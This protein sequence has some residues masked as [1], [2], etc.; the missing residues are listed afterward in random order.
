MK[1]NKEEIQRFQF[2][3]EEDI[4]EQKKNNV[5]PD[6]TLEESKKN[7][8]AKKQN[9]HLNSFYISFQFRVILLLC[10]ILICFSCGCVCIVTAL[11]SVKKEK[12]E[13]MES[14]DVEYK[15]CVPT[16]DPYLTNCLDYSNQ[17]LSS[18]VKEIQIDFDYLARTKSAR[19]LS[20]TYHITAINRIFDKFDSSKKLYENSEIVV[21]ET[22]IEFENNQA[23]KK[24]VF[25]IDFEKYNN[26]IL[27]YQKNYSYSSEAS[28]ELVVWIN[29]G[30]EEYQAG[31]MNIPLGAEK[32]IM[33]KNFETNKRRVVSI[34]KE[35]NSNQNNYYIVVGAVLI[36]LAMFA[37][38]YLTK[39]A[40]KTIN[41]QS[42]Y[43]K[44]LNELL[45][46][47]D[48]IIVEARGGY[49]SNTVKKVIKVPNFEE[50]LDARDMLNKPIIFSKVNNIKSEF[51]VEDDDKLY[52][53][54]LKEVDIEKEMSKK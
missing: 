20:L 48:R 16:D 36:L 7:K 24:S 53:Y 21:P 30:E 23:A 51:I 38:T 54:V 14:A 28:L 39:L 2:V 13:Y 40:L 34:K 12:V 50:L 52:K 6:D 5:E 41:R 27:E 32:F 11:N 26:F 18:N 47:Y 37:T 49:T 46:E 43:E 33:Y 9:S 17:F 44:R 4:S 29:N 42:K 35:D 3:E 1:K 19:E 8:T 25:Q 22:N 10:I 31:S 15:V 45:T